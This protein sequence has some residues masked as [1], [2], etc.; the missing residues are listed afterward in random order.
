M[1]SY[2]RLS[3]FKKLM[4][5][6]AIS[7]LILLICPFLPTAG[8]CQP[9]IELYE[10]ITTNF[11]HKSYYTTLNLC[12]EVIQICEMTPEPECWYTNIMKDIYRFKGITEFEIYKKELKPKRLSDAIESLSYSYNLFRDPDVQFLRGYLQALNAILIGDRN[13]LSGLVIAW[14]SLLS[15]HARNSWQ[16]TADIIDKIKLFIRVTEKF[17]EPIPSKNYSGIFARFIIVMACNLA[18]KAEIP[19][20]EKKYFVEIR[21][22]YCREEGRQ[23][24]NWRSGSNTRK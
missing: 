6:R 20:N 13:E 8:I 23:W 2:F 17:S 7:L 3:I 19:K 9:I 24:Q 18:D 21:L 16:V 22:K 14:Q 11:N 15:L 10:R 5:L 12:K 4:R 1:F